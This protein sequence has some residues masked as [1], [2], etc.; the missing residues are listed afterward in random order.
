MPRS[1]LTQRDNVFCLTDCQRSTFDPTG[2]A[3]WH[4][5]LEKRGE[6]GDSFQILK[7]TYP[8]TGSPI[9]KDLFFRYMHTW[10]QRCLYKEI[11][12]S[13]RLETKLNVHQQKT[14]KVNYSKCTKWNTVQPLKSSRQFATY[15]D[16]MISEIMWGSRGKK[17]TCKTACIGCF[18][19]MC[20][21]RLS[22]QKN[23]VNH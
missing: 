4:C 15:Q 6:R 18:V 2:L 8:L 10:A 12:Y 22:L 9:S 1:P 20:V 16:G 13:Q 14:C 19:C 3:R 21:H 7:C 23:T 5:E 17:A 11:Y